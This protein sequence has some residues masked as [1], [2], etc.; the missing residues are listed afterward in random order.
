VSRQTPPTIRMEG[1]GVSLTPEA[2]MRFG[3]LGF[4]YTRP[5]ESVVG[6]TFT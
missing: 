1:R 4:V 2:T 6:C 5:A 3:S